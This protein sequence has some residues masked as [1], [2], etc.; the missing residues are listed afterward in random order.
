MQRDGNVVGRDVDPLDQQP[1][2]ASL[3]GRVELVPDRLE[4][5]EGFDDIALLELGVLS[6][7]VRAE[8]RGDGPRDQRGRP[9][10]PMY[11]PEDQS[12]HLAGRAS[13]RDRRPC[14]RSGA[15]VACYAACLPEVSR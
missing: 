15:D 4:R 3:L 11:L 9:E 6:R 13:D 5:P 2:D 1:E 8:H 10:Q 14:G 12:L 7:A